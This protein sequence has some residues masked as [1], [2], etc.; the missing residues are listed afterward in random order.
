MPLL[1]CRLVAAHQPAVAAHGLQLESQDERGDLS[2]VEDRQAEG[3][4]GH[5]SHVVDD[6]QRDGSIEA[7]GPLGEPPRGQRE[8]ERADAHR[9]E[10]STG[11]AHHEQRHGSEDGEGRMT[12]P[13]AELLHQ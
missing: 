13:G 9:G 12:H 1:G 2:R 10:G 8:R 4:E 7:P 11:V 5:D 3:P 6:V